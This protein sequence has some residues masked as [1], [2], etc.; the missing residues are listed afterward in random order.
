[1]NYSFAIVTTSI[2]YLLVEY[3]DLFTTRW[4]LVPYHLPRFSPTLLHGGEGNVIRVY[5][6]YTVPG[7]GPYSWFY[8]GVG[9][10]YTLLLGHTILYDGAPCI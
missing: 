6:D 3:S 8:M 2:S 9:T 4:F 10:G 1:M 5:I 7:E